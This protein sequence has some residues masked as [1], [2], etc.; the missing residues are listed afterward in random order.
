MSGPWDDDTRV[1]PA[2]YPG[3]MP[4]DEGRAYTEQVATDF[5]TAMSALAATVCVVAAAGPTPGR[6]G[7]TA[8]AVCSLSSEPPQLVACLNRSSSI[9]RQLHDTGWFTVNVL[10]ASQEDVAATFAGRGGLAGEQR[11]D[12]ALW[13]THVTGTPVLRGATATFVCHASASLQQATH[14]IVVGAV[15]D[16]LLGADE[17]PPPLMYH[18]RRFTSVQPLPVEVR[19][20]PP[21]PTV[22]ETP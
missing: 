12:D 5:R 14:L 7:I 18:L 9:A 17:P 4:D 3:W 15:L 20:C 1:T 8:T 2:P 16:V 21:R 10:A 22:Q 11:F 6:T 13:S 19:N